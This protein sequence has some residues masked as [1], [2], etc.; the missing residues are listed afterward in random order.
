MGGYMMKLAFFKTF[1]NQQYRIVFFRC[2]FSFH[3][4]WSSCK[5][6]SLL[7]ELFLLPTL[8]ID[9]L[10]CTMLW[11]GRRILLRYMNNNKRLELYYFYRIDSLTVCILK[12]NPGIQ[13]SQGSSISSQ[14][15]NYLSRLS[16]K[17]HWAFWAG[18]APSLPD[19]DV[20]VNC[21]IWAYPWPSSIPAQDELNHLIVSTRSRVFGF[22]LRVYDQNLH[23][24][25]HYQNPMQ[26]LLKKLALFVDICLSVLFKIYFEL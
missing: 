19:N 8:S 12:M 23:F 6:S 17:L 21:S 14:T 11:P 9:I 1:Q 16:L 10:K 2:S 13:L 4:L 22:E 3:A 24:K 7:K 15:M 20:L 5:G 25:T 18:M 26:V